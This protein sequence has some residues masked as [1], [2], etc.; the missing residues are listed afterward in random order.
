M[1]SKHDM[2]SD[3]GSTSGTNPVSLLPHYQSDYCICIMKSK[4]QMHVRT[5]MQVECIPLAK[6]TIIPCPM[7]MQKNSQIRVTQ[8]K[9][10]LAGP[11]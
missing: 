9:S 1:M 7:P 4:N 5:S 11:H 2:H 8:T 3:Y 10:H 6:A